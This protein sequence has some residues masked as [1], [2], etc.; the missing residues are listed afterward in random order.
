ML[1]KPPTKQEKEGEIHTTKKKLTQ[2]TVCQELILLPA[3]A[4]S[5]YPSHLD[6]YPRHEAK[7]LYQNMRIENQKNKGENL[8]SL[9]SQPHQRTR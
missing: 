1:G 2:K 3:N 9:E 6:G 8:P 4:Q 7:N 5:R